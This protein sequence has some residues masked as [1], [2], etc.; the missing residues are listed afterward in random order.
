MNAPVI[1]KKLE[2]KMLHLIDEYDVE[3]IDVN[4]NDIFID[5]NDLAAYLFELSDIIKYHQD[6]IYYNSGSVVLSYDDIGFRESKIKKILPSKSEIIKK[7]Q[8]IPNVICGVYFLI[9]N[10]EIVYVGQSINIIS[11]IMAHN[12]DANKT[13]DSVSYIKCEKE[14]LD[15]IESYYINKFLPLQNG[16]SKGYKKHAPLSYEKSIQRLEKLFEIEG[17]L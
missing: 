9:L 8:K 16:N 12:A 14:K 13:F 7:S 15:A 3:I 4:G 10:N 6:F 5:I 1:P 17:Y 11:R 2:I